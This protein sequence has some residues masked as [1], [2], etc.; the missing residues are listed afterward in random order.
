MGY[1]GVQKIARSGKIAVMFPKSLEKHEMKFVMVLAWFVV[2][3]VFTLLG[4]YLGTIFGNREHKVDLQIAE[5][6]V[7]RQYA[8]VFFVVSM[9]A[10][11]IVSIIIPPVI[12]KDYADREAKWD[13]RSHGHH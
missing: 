11:I 7:G 5:I 12:E 10:A 13:N 6:H 8:L 3:T 1:F 4:F 2:P 9:V